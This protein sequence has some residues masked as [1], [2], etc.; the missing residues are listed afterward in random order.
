MFLVWRLAW[1]SNGYRGWDDLLYREWL[2]YGR[3]SG[4]G[5]VKRYGFGHEWWNFY[6]GF[7]KEYYYG[8]APPI[9]T[10]KPTKFRDGG[11]ILFISTPP[12]T[13]KWYLVGIYGQAKILDAPE[14]ETT[15][16]EL[17]PEKYKG[18]IREETAIKLKGVDYDPLP[19]PN[20]F[21]IK[22]KKEY[23]TPMPKPMPMDL[24]KDLKVPMMGQAMFMYTDAETTLNLLEKA[25]D[26]IKNLRED[27]DTQDLWISNET[28][29]ERLAKL[30]SYIYESDFLPMKKQ[31]QIVADS[32]TIKVEEEV[33]HIPTVRLGWSSW[34]PWRKLELDVRLGGVSPPDSPGVY[35][36]KYEGCDERLVI[37]KASN[38]RMRVKQGL[39][40]GKVPHSAGE[41]IRLNEDISRI[42]VRWAE[43]DRPAA[44]EEELHKRHL[45]KFGK[46]P[47]YVEHT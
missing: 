44:A 27:K 34:V 47:K 11:I 20:Y 45:E 3:C 1:C 37:G 41:K 17:I 43:T 16:W 13:R 46:L 38:L 18:V 40:K 19:A 10:L 29:I 12:Q 5:Y 26:F 30:I 6:E 33:L 14:V 2:F 36:A 35:E 22:A 42:V 7:S 31:E 24:R 28:A 4:F 21:V 32:S 8:Y 9:H 25:M 39:V 15:L 23:S